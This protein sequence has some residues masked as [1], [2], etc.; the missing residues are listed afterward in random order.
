MRLEVVVKTISIAFVAMM[1]SAPAAA[2]AED[3]STD[4]SPAAIYEVISGKTCVGDGVL[5]FG[6]SAPGSSGTFTRQG[7]PP[8][9]YSVGYGTIMIRRDQSLHGHIASVSVANHVLYMST[10]L[11]QCDP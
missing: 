9:T 3:V 10:G 1:C 2:S 5:V 4:G 11:Y 7:R 8:G 6:A